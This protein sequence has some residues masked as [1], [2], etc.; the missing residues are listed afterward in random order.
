ML[1][2]SDM[3]CCKSNNEK[4]GFEVSR[5]AALSWLQRPGIAKK[6]DARNEIS[7]SS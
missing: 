7:Y 5:S 4:Y 6:Q 3:D 1:V 2:K